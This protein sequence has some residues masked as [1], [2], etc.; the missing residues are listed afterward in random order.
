MNAKE[1]LKILYRE[2]FKQVS[3]KGSHLKLVK[4][5][6]K[7]IIP[8][9]GIKDIPIGTLKSIEKQSGIKLR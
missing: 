6:K 8:L 5:E 9:H 1:V 2:G 7:V 4:D 3:Q